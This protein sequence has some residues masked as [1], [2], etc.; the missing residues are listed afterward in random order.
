MPVYVILLS[1]TFLILAQWPAAYLIQNV[2]ITLGIL[3]NEILIVAGLPIG[4]VRHWKIPWGQIFPFRRP[5]TRELVWTV[6]MTLSLVVLI[7]YLTFLSEK[8]WAPPGAIKN[9]L[10]R[11]MA[12]DNFPDGAW[13]WF[14]LCLTPAFCEELF[15]RGFFQRSLESHWGPRTALLATALAFTFIHGIPQYW[16]LYFIL[17][18]YLSWLLFIR[19]N[20]WF[21]I[22]AHLLNNSWTYLTHVLG[23][24]LP[25]AETWVPVNSLVMGICILVFAFSSL[26][27]RSVVRGP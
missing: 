27:F 4:L 17:G 15:F 10:E 3:L 1:Y 13:R 9:M 22:L 18:L 26:R 16:H 14:L 5:K 20:L 11:L 23:Y 7:D 6:V 19:Q 21:P 8:I 2:S 24:T 12:V 25:A